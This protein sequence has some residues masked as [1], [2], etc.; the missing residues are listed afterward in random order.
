MKRK[1]D[2][3]NRSELEL[4]GLSDSNKLQS[5]ASNCPH[6]RSLLIYS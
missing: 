4:E 5:I 6:Y 2:A 3:M 1:N